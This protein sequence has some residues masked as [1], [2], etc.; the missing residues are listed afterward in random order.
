MQYNQ[1]GFN[2]IVPGIIENVA[3]I[4]PIGIFNS[5]AGKGNI[6]DKCQIRTEP[7][8]SAG[9]FQNETRCSPPDAG[10]QCLP[11]VF[12][13]FQDK[14]NIKIKKNTF[15]LIIYIIIFF[16]IIFILFKKSK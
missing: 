2:G 9:N 6:S 14:N 5:L 10:I 16:C 15:N 11:A 4:N 8:G 12:E 7:V 3:T 1:T 13:N